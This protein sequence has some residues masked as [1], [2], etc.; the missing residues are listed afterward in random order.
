MESEEEGSGFER[1]ALEE[2]ELERGAEDIEDAEFAPHDEPDGSADTPGSL[3]EFV[4]EGGDGEARSWGAVGRMREA[5][6]SDDEVELPEH[7]RAAKS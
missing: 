7:L 5:F 6:P 3:A 1:A 4:E 2:R